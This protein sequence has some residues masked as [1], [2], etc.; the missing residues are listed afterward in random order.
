[1]ARLR[2]RLL[3][4]AAAASA[5]TAG[6]LPAHSAPRGDTFAKPV[7]LPEFDGG[8][9]SLA[10]DPNGTGGVYVTAPQ[11][12]GGG[13]GVGFWGSSDHG[14]TFARRARI[15]SAFGGGDS[16]VEVGKD[17]TVYV[18][19]L[20]AAA[21]AVCRSTDHGKTF[22]DAASGQACDGV[23][24]SQYGFVSDREWLNHGPA[25][26]LYLTYHDL[27]VE[28][29][30]T[31]RSDDQGRTFTPCG[32]ASFSPTGGEWQKF[33]PGPTSGTQ[34][35][36]PVIGREGEIYTMFATGDPQG[37]GGFDHLWLSSTPACTPA[38]VFTS[39]PI[40]AH[41]GADLAQP[42]DGLGMDGGGTLYV[43]ASGTLGTGAKNA[44]V[45]LFRSDDHGRTWTKPVRVNTPGLRANML[46][47]VAGGLR[48][49]EVTIGW[50][51][52]SGDSNSDADN[53]WRYYVASS[54]DGGRTFTRTAVSPVMHHGA[55]ARALLDFTTVAVEPRT[56]AV[57][58]VFAGDADGPRRA[59][60]VRQTGGRFLR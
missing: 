27:H 60:V 2:T 37:D 38:S 34:V 35:P 53:A 30:Y 52:A 57:F 16:D 33:T 48:R 8:E 4:L 39:H 6:M 10:I 23:V 41:A 44:D 59:Y 5:V 32:P 40:Y 58:A 18:A 11:G 43:I 56:G 55:Q 1:M 13:K 20:E 36:K 49:G 22:V 51:G 47:S 19:D 9:P 54:F 28:F 24:G 12:L 29:P 17:G 15:G 3:V 7:M 42:F 50:Y 31:L 26:E 45:W 25:G 46:P 21:N 14:R